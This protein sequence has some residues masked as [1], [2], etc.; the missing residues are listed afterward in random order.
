MGRW[1]QRSAKFCPAQKI[2]IVHI[3]TKGDFAMCTC[4][5]N[6][7]RFELLRSGQILSIGS[8]AWQASI[9]SNLSYLQETELG[10]LAGGWTVVA[11]LRPIEGVEGSLHRTKSFSSLENVF[12]LEFWLSS[13]ALQLLSLQNSKSKVSV[14]VG[15]T[16]VSIV[17][18]LFK[19]TLHQRWDKIHDILAIRLFFWEKA[20]THRLPDVLSRAPQKQLKTS[21]V[22]SAGF[23]FTRRRACIVLKQHSKTF[24]QGASDFY[25]KKNP[26][27]SYAFVVKGVVV[28]QQLVCKAVSSS[29]SH[30]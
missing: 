11:I 18:P 2:C 29:L 6:C 25:E 20:R 22:L 7:K 9:Y 27:P 19:I 28:V 17:V 23:K 13:W 30:N 21:Q 26:P 15:H 4:H 5:K 12:S 14:L 8:T 24:V 16:H 1:H 10:R 3:K